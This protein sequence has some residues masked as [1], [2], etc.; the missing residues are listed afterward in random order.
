M[1]IPGFEPGI[2]TGIHGI[3]GTLE[4]LKSWM[5][6][7]RPGHDANGHGLA[8]Q[9]PLV[10][11][12]RERRKFAAFVR[13]RRCLTGQQ[14]DTPGDEAKNGGSANRV[15]L[16]SATR[17]RRKSTAISHRRPRLTGQPRVKPAHDGIL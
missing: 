8:D 11:A 2:V 17:K 4:T 10:S 1:P 15:P 6:G 9:V 12:G 3:G 13:W 5:A 7:T 16:V 14:W